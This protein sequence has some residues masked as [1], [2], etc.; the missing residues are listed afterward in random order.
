MAG[1]EGRG[2]TLGSVT[3]GG[4][5]LGGLAMVLRGQP[6]SALV[7]HQKPGK[8]FSLTLSLN[9]ALIMRVKALTDVFFTFK[10]NIITA[11]TKT[12]NVI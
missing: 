6:T 12:H 10:T 11:I 5:T 3:L 2:V 8:Y 7:K 9:F 4:V 1:S